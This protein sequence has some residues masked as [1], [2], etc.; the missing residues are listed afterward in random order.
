MNTNQYPWWSWSSW[1]T[2]YIIILWIDTANR[3]W[4]WWTCFL[5]LNMTK[6]RSWHVTQ[7]KDQCTLN[8]V[9]KTNFWSRMQWNWCFSRSN[10]AIHRDQTLPSYY[11]G[12]ASPLCITYNFKGCTWDAALEGLVRNPRFKDFLLVDSSDGKCGFSIGISKWVGICLQINAL[13]IHWKHTASLNTIGRKKF[14]SKSSKTTMWKSQ[15]YWTRNF[16][17]LWKLCFAAIGTILS[18]GWYLR[19]WRYRCIWRNR[20]LYRRRCC[21]RY[22][23]WLFQPISMC[24]NMPAS[25][26]ISRYQVL[27]FVH[28]LIFARDS[29][30]FSEDHIR[31]V[32][33]NRENDWDI[34]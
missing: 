20:M 27:Y 5:F 17:W 10:L 26:I 9:S 18:R 24:V 6:L 28:F 2:P 15:Q 34:V 1:W 7:T 32:R 4:R 13:Q 30:I 12:C 31:I 29:S 11:E 25:C 23:P 16:H 21:K 8:S 19:R 22:W 14:Q 3:P 33:L